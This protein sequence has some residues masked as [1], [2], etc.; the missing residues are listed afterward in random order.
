MEPRVLNPS[1]ALR[2]LRKTPLILQALLAGYTDSAL[3]VRNDGWSVVEVIVHMTQYED[4]IA[5]RIDL[6]LTENNP[7][8]PLTANRTLS[9]AELARLPEPAAMVADLRHG[10][11]QLIQR[12][13]SLSDEQW[14]RT[15]THPEQG[16]ATVLDVA[17]NAGLHD[18]DHLEQIA[19]SL[20]GSKAA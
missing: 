3:K 17:I 6:M 11:G 8:F 1:K 5:Q 14:L 13:T 10:R 12:L 19:S 2:T 4:W 18:V 7:T 20:G 15:G 9:D 16:T